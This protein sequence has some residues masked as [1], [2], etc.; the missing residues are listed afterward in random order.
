MPARNLTGLMRGVKRRGRRAERQIRHRVVRY[1]KRVVC[2]I[3]TWSGPQFAP[4]YNPRRGNRLCPQCASSER[5]RALE[6]RL[7]QRGPVPPG[8]RL[9]EVA[10]IQ[11]VKRTALELG[12]DYT[13]VDLQSAKAEVLGD[14]CQVPFGDR[15]FDL[16]V[17]FHVLEH[18][19]DDRAAVCELAR[20]V[21]QEGEALV[22]VPFQRDRPTTFED[23]TAD[24]ADCERLYGQSDHVRIY[25][26]DV[27]ER[28]ATTGVNLSEEMWTQSFTP[29]QYRQ[30]VLAGDDDRFWILRST[31]P[32]RP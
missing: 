10:P 31:S 22:V 7:R 8:T 17:C 30:S 19:P 24:P 15:S 18:I 25:G 9:L 21:S 12:Y 13:S 32:L 20:V 14:L 5:Y 26:A 6:L 2:P 16:V 29:S 4:S 3:C 1:P 27:T 28:W 23:P 11:T